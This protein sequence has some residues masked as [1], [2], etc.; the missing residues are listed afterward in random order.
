MN[1]PPIAE[2]GGQAV[3][4]MRIGLFGGTFNPIHNGHINCARETAA[5]FKL[6][7]VHLI[8]AAIPPHKGQPGI[9]AAAHRLAMVR[10]A[11]RGAPNLVAA[12]L[13][14]IRQGTSYTVDTIRQYQRNAADG[15]THFL[16]MGLDSLVEIHTWK[17]YRRIFERIALI[18]MFR[19][20]AVPP[21]QSDPLTAIHHYLTSRIDEQYG[22]ADLH[23][24]FH[25]PRLKPVYYVAVHPQAISASDIRRRVSEGLS[26][27]GLVPPAVNDY[28]EARGLYR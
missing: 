22:R 7:R 1:R 2:S 6:D 17:S 19:P 21:P 24:S 18:V 3:Y 12:D 13:E 16:I 9:A 20:D 26:L 10:L 23:S 8:P 5:V 11:I 14:L 25:H 15:T 27:K 28:I 4:G